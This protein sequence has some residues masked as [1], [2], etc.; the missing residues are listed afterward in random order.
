MHLELLVDSNCKCVLCNYM[1]G[2]ANAAITNF[3]Y[4]SF[5]SYSPCLT[6][7]LYL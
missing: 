3:F 4:V 6:L 2:V 1:S 5:C 7:L